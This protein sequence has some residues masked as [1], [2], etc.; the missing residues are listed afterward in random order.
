[1][2]TG[3]LLL[4][5]DDLMDARAQA[6]AKELLTNKAVLEVARSGR[7]FRPVEGDSGVNSSKIFTLSEPDGSMYVAVFNFSQT[8]PSE[9]KLDLSR[10]GLS[11]SQEFN[12][13]DLWK[14]TS[15]EVRSSFSVSLTPAESKILHITKR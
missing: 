14:D 8:Q 2:I 5:S 9:M 13:T 12:A 11:A 15:S 6:R 10:L 4:D 3:T 1:V 7:A